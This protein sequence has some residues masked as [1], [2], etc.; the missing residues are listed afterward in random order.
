MQQ[1]MFN[2]QRELPLALL[3]EIGY[4][5]SKGTGL[6]GR[7]D[8]NQARLNAPGENLPV[9][10]RR[11]FQQFQ[12]I[13]EF[14]GGEVSNYHGMAVRV[15]RRFAQ[16]FALL[17][18]YTWSKSIDTES[19][20]IDDGASPHHISN[21]RRLDRGLSAFHLRHRFVGSAIWELPFGKGKPLLNGARGPLGWKVSGWQINTILQLHTGMPFSVTVAGDRSNTGVFATQRPNRIAD[22]NLPGS[23]RDPDRWFDTAAF[24]LN[25]LNTYGNA[26]RA[27]LFEDGTQTLDVLAFKSNYLG[28]GRYNLQFRAEFFNALNTV[29]FGRPGTTIDGA[30]FGR[31]THVGPARET[32][33]ALK[34]IF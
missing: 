4:S 9:Q 2:V 6:M 19:R 1:W 3:F 33:L 24:A 28:E 32:Q 20:S 14:E 10:A 8:L 25:P 21:N 27:I 30:N 23:Q 15:E 11:P 29:N 12:S 18:N 5:G 17:T 16:G 7:Q 31:V 34:L 22:G 13:L 26:G